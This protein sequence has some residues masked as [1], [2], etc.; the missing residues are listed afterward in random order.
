MVSKL[1][2]GQADAIL[3]FWLPG[4]TLAGAFAVYLAYRSFRPSVPESLRPMPNSVTWDSGI[5]PLQ[6][7]GSRKD[8]W[9]SVFPKR[10]RVEL[11]WRKLHSLHLRE[12]NDGNR[13]TVDTDAVRLNIAQSASEI[14]REWLYQLLATH[15]SLPLEQRNARDGCTRAE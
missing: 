1:S 7:Y 6:A 2:S 14:E 9:K 5:P 8:Y 3:V 10:T 13:L 4:W 12:T 15:Y 11:D